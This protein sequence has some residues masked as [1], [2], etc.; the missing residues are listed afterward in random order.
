[1]PSNIFRN[2]VAV[3]KRRFWADVPKFNVRWIYLLL[4]FIGPS[5]G[6]GIEA[7]KDGTRRQIFRHGA[8]N[9]YTDGDGRVVVGRRYVTRSQ[10]YAHVEVDELVF[11]N[12]ALMEDEVMELYNLYQ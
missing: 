7:F 4:N 5:G 12:K 9:T 8:S 11:F 6:E 2:Y 10:N 3:K 1:M